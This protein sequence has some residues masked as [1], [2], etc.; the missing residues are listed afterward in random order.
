M[1]RLFVMGRPYPPAG[2]QEMVIV[3]DAE[4]SLSRLKQRGFLLLVVTN[5]PDVGRGKS[6]REEVEEIHG[7]SFPKTPSRRFLH[8]LSRRPGWL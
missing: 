4:E 7:V 1:R 2:I 8:L 3:P 5:Q 6:S